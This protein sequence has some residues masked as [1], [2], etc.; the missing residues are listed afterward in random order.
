MESARIYA[1]TRCDNPY[2]GDLLGNPYKPLALNP[3]CSHIA[4]A[5]LR[6]SL[7]IRL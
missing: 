2:E 1:T 4:Q 5:P 7:Q 6:E 3:D